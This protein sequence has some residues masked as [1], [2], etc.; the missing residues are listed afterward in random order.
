M[1]MLGWGLAAGLGALAGT[2]IAPKLF[3]EP[4]MMAGVLIYSFAAATLGGFDSPVGAVLG[5]LIVGVAETL[6]GAYV[7]A[8]GSDLKVG[9]PLAVIIIVLLFRPQGLL[10]HAAVERA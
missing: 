2:M 9:V 6:A 7:H 10:G 8:I 1:L 4:N 3:L 5:G